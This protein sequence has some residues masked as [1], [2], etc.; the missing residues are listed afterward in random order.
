MSF[1]HALWLSFCDFQCDSF[2]LEEFYHA[3]DCAVEGGTNNVFSLTVKSIQYQT[4]QI[5]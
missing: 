1:I 5:L 2:I 3:F 4:E